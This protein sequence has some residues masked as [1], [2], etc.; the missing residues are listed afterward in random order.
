MLPARADASVESEL[1]AAQRKAN[2]AAA[3]L[4]RAESALARTQREVSDLQQRT[5]EAKDKVSSLS[6]AVRSSAIR[7]YMDGGHIPFVFTADID[8]SVRA[9]EMA[10]FV[11]QGVADSLDRFRAAHDDL[12]VASA[13]LSK[14]LSKRKSALTALKKRRAAALK[15]IDRLARLQREL[16]AR[17]RR[18]RSSRSGGRSITVTGS[19]MCPVQGPH[20]FSNDWGAPRGGGRRRHKGNDIIAPRGTPVVASVSGAVTRRSGGIGGLAYYLRG[21]DGNTYYG[22]HLSGFGASGSVSI[23]TVIGYVGTSGN[24]AGGPPHLHFEIHPGGG[25]AVNPYPTL[26]RYC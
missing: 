14:Q 8:E 10:R 16:A 26:A 18:S 13:A 11:T 25:A 3:A 12:E 15:E 6:E 1:K 21:N 20:A 19:W 4:S 17:A 5:A 23:G 7:Q 24:A 9:N 22:A 2:A